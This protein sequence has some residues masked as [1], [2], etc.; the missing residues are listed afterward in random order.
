[1]NVI[2]V[3]PG[4]TGAIAVLSTRGELLTVAD[5]PVVGEAAQR[6]VNA[7]GLADWIREYGPYDFAIVEQVASRP[8]Q[9]VSSTFKFGMSYGAVIG[10][11]AALA[12]PTR[13]VP[14]SKWK[15]SLGLNSDGEASRG[16]A[17]E[18]WP[19]HASLFARKCDH[20][21]A[22]ACLLALYGLRNSG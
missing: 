4:F 14:A 5:M 17:L 7:V 9:G 10:V 3:D 21:R 1:M 13:F 19:D 12:I 20:G 6:R 18:R 11:V 8:K 2:A 16:R 22:E 15:Q